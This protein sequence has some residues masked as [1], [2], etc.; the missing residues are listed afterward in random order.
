ML[1]ALSANRIEIVAAGQL[2]FQHVACLPIYSESKMVM[3]RENSLAVAGV[4]SN[5]DTAMLAT[6]TVMEIGPVCFARHTSL[7]SMSS[8]L[9]SDSI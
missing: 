4:Y 1:L 6:Y 3:E 2:L 8:R 7:L 5:R 9:R